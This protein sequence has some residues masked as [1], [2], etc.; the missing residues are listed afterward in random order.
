[1]W[2]ERSIPKLL[3][4]IPREI[5]TRLVFSLL[6]ESS[7]RKKTID[8]K[9][10]L[11]KNHFL[12]SIFGTFQLSSPSCRVHV[13]KG[14]WRGG[15][16]VIGVSLRRWGS[17]KWAKAK[18]GFVYKGNKEWDYGWMVA[19]IYYVQ[20]ISHTSCFME[21]FNTNISMLIL[22]YFNL[23]YILYVVRDTWYFYNFYSSI[24]CV[25]GTVRE[26][27]VWEHMMLI[28]MTWLTTTWS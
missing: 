1:M 28:L 3:P 21:M 7:Q 17:K 13:I 15:Q 9:S 5:S 11:A 6:A 24:Y 19:L 14:I 16:E 25:D 23:N 18:S 4:G 20:I 27:L 12:S 10:A 8:N 26:Q 2:L 22:N